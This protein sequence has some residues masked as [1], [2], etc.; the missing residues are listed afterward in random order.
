MA[1][2]TQ[3]SFGHKGPGDEPHKDVSSPKVY[4]IVFAALIALTVL[5]AVC[6]TLPLGRWEAVVALTIASVK[7][8]LV[9]L[10]FMHLIHMAKLN[11]VIVSAGAFWLS[12]AFVL[13]MAD[14]ATR[15]WYSIVATP[16]RAVGNLQE[17][18]QQFQEH[19]PAADD[20]LPGAEI[21]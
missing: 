17:V 8:A 20:T 1:S 18:E 10:F 14:Y 13:T 16:E 19:R 11:W 12:I 3:H 21:P 9:T 4:F 7:A 2:S 5:T 6:S 15:S